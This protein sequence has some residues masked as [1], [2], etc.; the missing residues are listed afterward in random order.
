VESGKGLVA[1]VTVL[2]D[3]GTTLPAT[4]IAPVRWPVRDFVLVHS[5]L[6]RESAYHLL[7]RW[8]LPAP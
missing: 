4:P 5:V 2:R 3:A 6:G 7:G 8:P 1:H